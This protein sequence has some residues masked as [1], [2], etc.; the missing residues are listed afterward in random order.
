MAVSKRQGNEKPVKIEQRK[1]KEGRKA[2]V[3]G[4]GE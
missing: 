2:A 4:R 3:R 1:V